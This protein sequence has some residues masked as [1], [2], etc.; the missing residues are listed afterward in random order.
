M[1]KFLVIFFLPLTFIE[2]K[3]LSQTGSDS[4]IYVPIRDTSKKQLREGEID[5]IVKYSANDSILFDLTEEKLYLYKDAELIYK[6]YKLKADR[7]ILYRENSLMEAYGAE[8]TSGNLAGTP[9]F[10][11]GS[12][13][14]DAFRLKYNFHTRRGTI[15]M[16][17]TEIEGGYYLGEKIKKVD[18][19]IYFIKG[20]RYTTCD[21]I[22]PDY[23]F[24]SPKMKVIQGD[25]VIA[26]PVFLYIDDV[27]VF[28]LPFGIFPNH[29]GRSSG[30][31]PPAYGEDA[32]YG[33]YLSRLGYFWAIN[34]VSYTH[35]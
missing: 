30:L 24:G 34:A 27:P 9:V 6:D 29:S 1:K 26:E 4:V 13:R 8:D 22:N 20:G 28:A 14:Y 10:Y 32:F 17:S 31:I 33:R 21:K 35:L 7:I 18:E 2:A 3:L 15:E 25:K 12:K 5:A 19:E 23:Y 11:E 16:G